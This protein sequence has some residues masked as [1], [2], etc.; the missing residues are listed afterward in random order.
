MADDATYILDDQIGF[1]LRQAHQRHTAIFA[2][3]MIGD[4]TPR[5]FSTLARLQTQ[6]PLS[7]NHLG[8]LTA[9]DVAT[10][11]GVVDRLCGRGLVTTEP[12][13]NDARR[14]VVALSAAGRDLIALALPVAALITEDTLAPLDA[15]ERA[16][17]VALLA[18]LR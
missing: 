3:R 16:A 18:K 14:R 11:K 7:Q 10:I 13:P 4:L 17:L 9:M 5:Q 8:R 6:G 15:S 2:S 12:D 1:V